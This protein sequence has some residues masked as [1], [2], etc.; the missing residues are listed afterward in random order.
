MP[1]PNLIVE[2]VKNKIPVDL[3]CNEETNEVSYRV[4]GFYKHGSVLLTENSDGSFLV[5]GRYGVLRDKL[6]DFAELVRLNASEW[7]TYSSRGYNPDSS[8]LPFLI[9]MNHIQEII[10]TSVEYR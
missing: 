10:K 8:W 7:R 4:S 9:E 5:V 6:C 2:L 1:I 3:V